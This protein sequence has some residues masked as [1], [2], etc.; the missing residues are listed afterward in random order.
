MRTYI[1]CTLAALTLS[2]GV[3]SNA[4]AG[5]RFRQRIRFEHGRRIVYQERY[6]V[7]VIVV[8]EPAP[9]ILTPVPVVVSEPAYST[10]YF[11]GC[12][13]PYYRVYHHQRHYR[14][15]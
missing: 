15:R 8:T 2:L 10:G 14:R 11:Y 3:T 7:P 1:L 5:W 4:S 9:A 12:S 13:R 6:W